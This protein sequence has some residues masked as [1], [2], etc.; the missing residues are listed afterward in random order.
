[1]GAHAHT[2]LLGLYIV[3]VLPS[4]KYLVYSTFGGLL[5]TYLVEWNQHLR[6]RLQDNSV[7]LDGEETVTKQNTQ[8][9][10]SYT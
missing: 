4:L 9:C 10:F 8:P 6:H 7:Q 1:M 3:V 2:N 5:P